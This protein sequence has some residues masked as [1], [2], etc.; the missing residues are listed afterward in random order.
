MNINRKLNYYIF[1]FIF[2]LSF[3]EISPPTDETKSPSLLINFNP[4]LVAFL[5]IPVKNLKYTKTIERTL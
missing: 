4:S 2:E 1:S 5:L 3:A